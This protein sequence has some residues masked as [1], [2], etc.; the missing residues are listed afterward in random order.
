MAVNLSGK[1]NL[2]GT[3]Y[4][5][6]IKSAVQET[7]KLKREVDSANRTMN[8]FQKGLSGASSSISSMMNSFKMGDIGGFIT[9][10]KGAATAITSMIPAA[11]GATAAVSTLGAAIYTALGPIGLIV[12]GIAGI[13]A[14]VGSSISSVENFNKSLNGLSAITGVEG[15]ELKDVGD[16]A[17]D[18]S[19][20]FGTSATD[21]VN[22]M[23]NIGSQAPVLLKDMDALG[24]VTEAAIV[25]SKAADNMTVEDSAKAITTVMNQ[26]GV[27]GE[28][29]TEIINSLAAGSK[30]GSKAVDYL[31]TAMEKAGTQ[32]SMAGMSYQ[33]TIAAIETLGLKISSA[34]VAGT[35]L[36]SMLIRLTTQS[37]SNFNPAIVGL[38]KALENLDKANLSAAE[39]LKLFG[40]GSLTVANQLIDQRE[41]LKDLTDKVTG[42]N[43][44]YEQMNIKSQSLEV[45]W[46]KLTAAWEAFMIKMGQSK[47]IQA[48]I[49]L[50]GLLLTATT[51]LI[52]GLSYLSEAVDTTITVIIALFKKLYDAVKPYWDAIVNMVTNSAIYKAVTKIWQSIYDFI[53]KVIRKI[54]K[55]WSNFMKE[56]GI[57]KEKVKEEIPNDTKPVE[58]D[59]NVNTNNTTKTKIDYEKGSLEYYKKE[60]QKLQDKLTKKKLSLIDIEKTKADIEKVKGIIKE[61]EIQIGLG[62]KEGTKAAIEKELSEI[63]EELSKLNPVIDRVDIEKLQIKK[64]ELIKL[65]KDVEAELNGAVI[66]PKVKI[67]SDANKGSG[68][69]ANDM[70]SVYKQKMQY[71]VDDADYEHWKKRYEEWKEKAEKFNLKFEEDTSGLKEGMIGFN[72][73]KISELKTKLK[74]TVE[75]SPEY[76]DTV[77]QIRE[78]TKQQDAIS[79]KVEMDLRGIGVGSL[80]ELEEKISALEAKLMI[81]PYGTDEFYKIQKDLK[82]L[83]KEDQKIRMKIE[84][85]NMDTFEKAQTIFDGFHAIDNVVGSISSLSQ[86]IEEDADAWTILMSTIST[87]ESVFAAVNTVMEIANFLTNLGTAGKLANATAST[88]A[89]GAATAEAAEETATV[90]AKTAEAAANKAL[91]SSVLDLAAAQI[92]LAHASIPFAGPGIASGLITTMMAAMAAQHA[93]SLSL[94][95]FAEGGIV[96]GSTT[97]GDN[98]LVRANKGEMILNQRQQNNLFREIDQN[99]M[100]T[101]IEPGQVEFVIKGDRLVGVIKNYEKIHK[102]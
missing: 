17:L 64:E 71:A 26:F 10:A 53:A 14:V 31:A 97:V 95:A 32:T 86:A 80:A 98:I 82:D 13:G 47:A 15:D 78:L 24:Q 92:F 88:A 12:G 29:A 72:D 36:S 99:R 22:S 81:T 51:K 48:I 55:I 84:W 5:D 52:N 8:S 33:Q 34:E 100:A 9:G 16:A 41:V 79:L 25:L 19:K 7:S 94:Q 57:E 11:G 73:K 27:E 28:K 39:K 91:E 50:L 1:L 45:T 18:M 62:P 30:L 42:T 44:A 38:D 90:P 21:I 61:K 76:Y 69:Y 74:F 46:N 77:N 75:G 23:S 93:A 20:K 102:K 37:N 101:N 68:K 87:I 35:G 58:T 70:V 66:T 40:A 6:S 56:L 67:E 96:K 89:G 54:R 3:G 83:T 63:E 59:V 49:G 60:L 43:T 2:D 85:E 65:K 4:N